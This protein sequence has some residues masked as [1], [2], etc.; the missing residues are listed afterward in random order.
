MWFSISSPVVDRVIKENI[1]SNRVSDTIYTPNIQNKPEDIKSIHLPKEKNSKEKETIFT[2]PNRYTKAIDRSKRDFYMEYAEGGEVV[3]P[4]PKKGVININLKKKTDNSKKPKHTLPT[5]KKGKIDINT[6][7]HIQNNF[8]KNTQN[9]TKNDDNGDIG[10][11]DTQEQWDIEWPTAHPQKKSIPNDTPSPPIANLNDQLEA[12]GGEL[13]YPVLFRIFKSENRLEVW[14]KVIDRYYHLINYNICKYSGVFGPKL[15]ADDEQSPEGYYAIKKEGL[16]PNSQ[17]LLSMDIGYPNEYDREHNRTGSGI[18]IYG[19]CESTGSFAM[20]D[21][22]IG[23]IYDLVDSAL[24]NGES[25]V[26]VYIYPFLM[27]EENMNNFRD[28]HWYSFWLNLKEGY[29]MFE[30]N[31]VPLD[32]KVE[33]GKYIFSID[34]PLPE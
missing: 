1:K 4:K 25:E 14:M 22:K 18:K 29:D 30:K 2:K 21:A 19:G 12:I 15:T 11:Y 23:E 32:I 9:S 10:E 31:F 33:N 6:S 24:E 17:Y 7:K 13:G 3:P 28:H 5:V 16:D 27:S 20:T 34:N 26:P 8:Q